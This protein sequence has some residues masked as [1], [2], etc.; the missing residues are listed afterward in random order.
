M[1]T[2][3]AAPDAVAAVPPTAH[4]PALPARLTF[5]GVLRAEWI[6]LLSLRSTWWVLTA[7][8]VLI[9]GVSLAV[10]FSLD[11][12]ATDPA[13]A[14]ATAALTGAEVVSGGFQLGMLTIAVLGTLLITGEYST[15]M[16]RSTLAAVPLAVHLE[17]A[18]LLARAGQAAPELVTAVDS[19][20]ELARA[21]LSEA[22]RAVATLRGDELPGPELVPQLVEE[23]RRSG[24]SCTLTVSGAPVPLGPEARLAVYR[25]VQEGLSNVRK[26]APDAMAEVTIRWASTEVVV[27][28][29]DHGG[30]P[31]RE[32]ASGSTGYGLTGIAERAE[33]LGGRFRATHGTNGFRVELTVPV[34]S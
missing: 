17:G 21:G 10:A 28:V 27:V 13:T 6:K 18:R 34:A 5:T 30:T 12:V 4:A 33:L 32:P 24:G 3:L 14:A 7:T 9:V 25:T 1:S 2:T 19:A 26:H 20:H 23:H 16:I 29:Q 22:R 31:A 15:G 11:A 8:V